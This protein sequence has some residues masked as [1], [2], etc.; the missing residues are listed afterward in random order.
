MDIIQLKKGIFILL[1]FILHL[2]V[3][4]PGQNIELEGRV[5]DINE[6]L[7]FASIAVKNTGIGT[8]SNGEGKFRLIVPQAYLNDVLCISM[9]GYKTREVKIQN[10]Q[11]DIQLEKA[12]F[13]LPEVS[14]MPEDSM[15][16]FMKKA[17]DRIPENYL[18]SA[19]RQTGFYRTTLK[20]DTT[21]LYFGE[22]LLDVYKPSYK[23]RESGSVKIL[24]SRITKGQ[25]DKAM[26]PFYFYGGIYMPFKSDFVQRRE[27]FLNP[28]EFK[29]YSYSIA[30]TI[31]QDGHII[32]KVA[33]RPKEANKG[34]YEGFFHVDK[35][36]LAFIE[37]HF[38]Y[39]S[40]GCYQRSKSLSS[41][42]SVKSLDGSFI[43]KYA[44]IDNRYFLKYIL[45]IED[46]QD[47]GSGRIYKKTNEYLTSEVDRENTNPIPLNEQDM[48][49]TVF[50]I[51]ATPVS[52]ST[53][54]DY[55]VLSGA[56]D[57]LAY[58]E[59]Q[60]RQILSKNKS[61]MG[62]SFPKEKLI[63]FA[64]R[65]Q[66]AIYVNTKP[67]N[68]RV[69]ITSFSYRPANQHTFQLQRPVTQLE[70]QLNM[71]MSFGYNLTNRYNLFMTE[72]YGINCHKWE[73]YSLG[74][75]YNIGLKTYGK[76]LLLSPQ[77]SVSSM[78]Y[79]ILLGEYNNPGT[80]IT[81]NKKINADKIK[82]YL[83]ER[84]F[85]IQPGLTVKKD[86]SRSLKL[87]LGVDYCWKIE[88]KSRLYIDES[89]GFLFR[90][91]VNIPL[92]RPEITYSTNLINEEGELLNSSF[93]NFKT[94][95]IFGR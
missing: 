67:V 43:L 35:E 51:K 71:G 59:Q 30:E 95:I 39:T 54:K 81:G 42:K 29:H 83:G 45:Y 77:L 66:S 76:R 62:A 12:D 1:L 60:A 10:W 73:A 13:L 19:T 52:E 4:L 48:F 46:F 5:F 69:E 49:S 9:I 63:R 92:N 23:S 14:I 21:Y 64:M 44:L 79:G 85:G 40:S 7:P 22:A 78:T 36:T 31:I 50:S 47:A 24:N 56:P 84:A 80:F 90:K 3:T 87:F 82:L 8:I 6:P 72:E 86:L 91:K 65:V 88:T 17:V 20:S 26:P 68:D 27:D 70:N 89:S 57:Q 55:N 75:S 61:K 2:P 18:S 25:E 16:R 11:K 34:Y 53:W 28:A 32:Y 38:S 15:L 33:F 58:S 41:Y 74:L 37:F 93:F 94:G